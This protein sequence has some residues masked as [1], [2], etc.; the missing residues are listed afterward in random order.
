MTGAIKVAE[1]NFARKGDYYFRPRGSRMFK[2][3]V[4]FDLYLKG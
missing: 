1:V 3:E 4:T 2:E